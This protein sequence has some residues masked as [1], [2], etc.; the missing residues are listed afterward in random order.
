M[1]STRQ[2]MQGEP[3]FD[4][5]LPNLNGMCGLYVCDTSR[6]NGIKPDQQRFKLKI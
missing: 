5:S 4:P 1:F 2:I 6:Y 3:E